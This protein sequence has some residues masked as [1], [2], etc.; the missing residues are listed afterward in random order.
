MLS[1]FL[2]ALMVAKRCTLKA[3]RYTLKAL[4]ATKEGVTLDISGDLLAID[5]KQALHHL[6]SITSEV[7]TDVS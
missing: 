7:T 6:G 2:V 4:I 5:I 3:L 1:F